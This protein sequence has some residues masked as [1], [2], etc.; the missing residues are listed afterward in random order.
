MGT[1]FV[2][3]TPIGNLE[4]ITLRALK[5]LFAVDIIAC[6]DTRR[7]GLLLDKLLTN[8]AANPEDKRKPRLISYYE[9]NELQRIPEIVELLR[10]GQNIA[11]VSDA[12][13]P[14]V[15]DPGF[16][17]V[18]ECIVQ[19]IKVEALPGASS[20]LTALTVSGLPTD[21]FFFAGYP[22][23]KPGHR[24]AFLDNL[25]KSQELVK[26]TVILFEAPHKLLTTL[27]NLQAVFGDIEV[28]LCRELT[29]IYEEVRREKISESL[30]HFEKIAPKGEFVLL[31]NLNI[32]W[33]RNSFVS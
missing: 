23:H 25:K 22:P 13:T 2:V 31:F 21:K 24:L 4:D 14:L 1:L 33:E 9:Q 3:A 15:S 10:V 32:K 26:S 16:K 18:R 20:V 6:E 8:F 11:L 12:G 5:T 7:T 30:I 19:G 28:V 29:K 17:L 27:G